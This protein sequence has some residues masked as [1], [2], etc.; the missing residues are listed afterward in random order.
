LW[1]QLAAEYRDATDF[2]KAEDAYN[3]SLHL[4]KT[5]PPAQPQY[6]ATL[7][8][9]ASLYLSYGRLDD[10]ES[11]G[12][13]ALTVRQKLGQP[14]DI[15]VSQLRLADIALGRHEFKKAERLAL[16][17]LPG[18]ESSAGSSKVGLLS[19]FMALTYARCSLGHC[20]EGLATAKQAVAFAN[21]NF[22]SDSAP[23]GFALQT[24][25]YAEWKSGA[26]QNC[27]KACLTV[28]GYF[29]MRCRRPILA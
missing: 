23:A 6:A 3:R 26:P 10:A 24:L 13:Q 22:E 25:G 27:E 19:A 7:D 14:A 16:Q 17:G 9:L 15:A 21:S 20:S 12:K 8:E 2:S 4:L 5:S 18:M 11:V 1:A 28:S 29:G